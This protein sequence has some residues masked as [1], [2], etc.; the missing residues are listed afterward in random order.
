MLFIEVYGLLNTDVLKLRDYSVLLLGKAELCLLFRMWATFFFSAFWHGV[1]PG[2][3]LTFMSVPMVIVAQSLMEKLIQPS[4]KW[5]TVYDWINWFMLYR[6]FE[7]LSVAFILLEI[8]AIIKTWILMCFYNHI[9][10][11]FCI[12]L[13]LV[14]TRSSSAEHKSK[15]MSEYSKKDS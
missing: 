9:L 13:P 10:I 15:T 4:P 3:Y 6:S 12:V 14:L 7:Y 2:Y 8:E 11:I 1:Q 5:K